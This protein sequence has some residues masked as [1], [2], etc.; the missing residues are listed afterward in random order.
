MTSPA[1]RI[2]V[3]ATDFGWP[4]LHPRGFTHRIGESLQVVGV[5]QR[6]GKFAGVADDLPASGDRQSDRMFLAQVI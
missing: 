5:W 4:D 6:G 2:P 1:N 3:I